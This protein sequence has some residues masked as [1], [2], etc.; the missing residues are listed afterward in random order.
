[1]P[2]QGSE[3]T[4]PPGGVGIDSECGFGFCNP[5]GNGFTTT[6]DPEDVAPLCVAEPEVC[7]GVL[8]IVGVYEAAPVVVNKITQLVEGQSQAKASSKLDR[9]SEVI[10]QCQN[11]CAEQYA[12]DPS[13][14]PGTGPDMF[15]RVRRCIRECAASQG[16][17]NF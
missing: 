6:V 15:G 8:I 12:N 16:C 1:M 9:C 5:F 17:H 3:G 2:G 4:Y 13:S 14:L 11:T 10:N 7:I